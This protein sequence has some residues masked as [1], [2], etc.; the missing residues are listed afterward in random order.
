MN[1]AIHIARRGRFVVA[2]V[3][4]GLLLTAAHGHYVG[5]PISL[6]GTP[7]LARAVGDS[8]LSAED[9]GGVWWAGRLLAASDH[10]VL[11]GSEGVPATA[12]A[13]GEQ[14]LL[15]NTLCAGD[16]M[17][18][19]LGG[20]VVEPVIDETRTVEVA[21]RVIGVGP[22]EKVLVPGSPGYVVLKVGAVSGDVVA[23]ETVVTGTP[24]L[25]RHVPGPGSNVVALTFDDGP[26]PGQ[27]E[28]IL[29]I[30]EQRNVPATFFMLGMLVERAPEL[31]RAT[32][33]AGHA[34]GNHTYWHVD[35]AA[36]SPDTAAWEIEGTNQMIQAATGIRPLWIRAPGGS[37]RGPAQAYIA[38]A[39]MRSALWTV[40]PQDWRYGAA[41][42]DLAW[43]VIASAHPGAVIVLHDGGGDQST[44]VAAL[45]III[46]GLRANGYEF[47]TL[48]ELPVVR[49]GW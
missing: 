33:N 3:L 31:A 19:V 49:A 39:S 9:T 18:I 14:A 6:S 48:D 4:V 1:P 5:A 25:V 37:L 12:S 20:D 29:S 42:E 32:A 23:T 11:F 26:W 13:D 8:T 28:A 2:G 44:T 45:P 41:P 43:S 22:V 24:A 16:R 15:I 46:D 36:A 47:V 10:R 30:L 21:P 40:D 17:C 34:I 7:A 38:G 35:L 27:T